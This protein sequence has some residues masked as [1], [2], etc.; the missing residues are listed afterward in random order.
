MNPTLKKSKRKASPVTDPQ[1]E[2][3]PG[4]R[5][6]RDGLRPAVPDTQ[7]KSNSVKGQADGQHETRPKRQGHARK[8]NQL[9]PPF[10]GTASPKSKRGTQNDADL[11]DWAQHVI[12]EQLQVMRD[13]GLALNAQDEDDFDGVFTADHESLPIQNTHRIFSILVKASE[14]RDEITRFLWRLAGECLN[15]SYYGA[16]YGYLEKMLSLVDAPS[17]KAECL[18]NMG[19]VMEQ[20]GQYQAALEAYLQAFALPQ[21][22]NDIWYFLNN[23]LGYCLNQTGRYQEAEKYCRAAIDIEPRRHNAWKNVGIAFQNQQRYAEAAK[24]FVHATR[25]CPTDSRAL[26]HLRDLI[27]SH[28]E[29]LD[30]IPDL[31]VWLHECHEAVQATKGGV[32]LQ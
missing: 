5:H 30:E 25:L 32:S 20:S 1:R 29:I 31:L 28:R 27:G 16:A 8:P 23:N 24:C 22:R 7:G 21:E 19:I 13:R 15:S 3:V 17:A 12:E 11:D 14:N 4:Q 10:A 2:S 9:P 18:L 26:G 6:H